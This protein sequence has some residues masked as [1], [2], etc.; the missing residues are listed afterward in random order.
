MMALLVYEP[1]LGQHVQS[2]DRCLVVAPGTEVKASDASS[3]IV[4]CPDGGA[5]LSP[6]CGSSRRSLLGVK[7]SVVL[8]KE[9]EAQVK[10]HFDARG[11]GRVPLFANALG[12]Y[13][14]SQALARKCYRFCEKTLHLKA[15]QIHAMCVSEDTTSGLLRE[16]DRLRE[17]NEMLKARLAEGAGGTG[18]T[19]GAGGTEGT[20]GVCH[21]SPPVSEIRMLF[22]KKGRGGRRKK[23]GDAKGG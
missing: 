16:I 10:A 4:L 19:E 6:L 7:E 21:K 8:S 18:G 12:H 20:G 2:L 14:K 11:G 9:C 3:K 17:E 1:I 23:K 5:V 13:Y 15:S 22:D